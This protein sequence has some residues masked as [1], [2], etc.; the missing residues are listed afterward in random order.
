MG[1]NADQRGGPQGAKEPSARPW[2]V[3][4]RMPGRVFASPVSLMG[5]LSLLAFIGGMTL[6]LMNV[7][8]LLMGLHPL[9]IVLIMLLLMSGS[10]LLFLRLVVAKGREQR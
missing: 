1:N 10:I 6:I 2:F 9:V 4:T 3:Y 7:M 8:P 5:W